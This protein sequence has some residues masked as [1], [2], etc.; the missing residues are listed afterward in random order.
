MNHVKFL[1]MQERVGKTSLPCYTDL[2]TGT[3]FLVCDNESLDE[4]L[5]R[6]REKFGII[7]DNKQTELFN[8]L[9]L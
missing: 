8:E 4:A 1:G 6:S 3:T 2:I 7:E 5:I 9:S